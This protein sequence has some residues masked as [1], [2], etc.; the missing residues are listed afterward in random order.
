MHP[1]ASSASIPVLV[2]FTLAVSDARSFSSSIKVDVDDAD[3]ERRCDGD[4]RS[5][6]C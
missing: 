4:G 2:I 6:K 1:E 5:S 3:M